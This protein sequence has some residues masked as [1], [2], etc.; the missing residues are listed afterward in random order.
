MLARLWHILWFVQ[1]GL[2]LAL[3]LTLFTRDANRNFP[4]F[5]FY[6]SWM[7]LEGV[8]LIPIYYAPF[9]TGDQYAI[10]FATGIA[11]ATV[12]RF[13]IIYEIFTRLLN[14]YPALRDAGV[15]VFRWATVALL[16]IVIA[17]AWFVPAAGASRVM[18]VFFLL[19]RTVDVLLC[20]LLLFLFAFSGYFHLSWRSY[21]VGISLGLGVL[22]T[23]GLATA[24]IRAQ[25]EPLTR[26]QTA[27]IMELIN[28]SAYTFSALI[29]IA[30]L[31]LPER[32]RGA[33]PTRLPK[34]DLETWNQE[35]QRFLHQ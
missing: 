21:L 32:P 25:I 11:G 24:S 34:H 12:L 10:A 30:Y 31:F 35:L 23:V 33:T 5:T 7:A 19:Q 2:Y 16:V 4:V 26:N 6:V 13:A 3:S 17:L 29:W 18:S 15:S 9:T 27:D 20:G 1:A 28:Q 8:I 14:P 22:A